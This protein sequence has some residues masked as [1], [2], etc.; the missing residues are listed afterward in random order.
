MGKTKL[1]VGVAFLA[2]AVA[3]S[4]PIASVEVANILLKDDIQDM[5][6]QFDVRT[7]YGSPKSNED[8]RQAVVRK[9][10]E[11]GIDLEDSQV[12]VERSGAGR[13][14][15]LYIAADYTESFT[16]MGVDFDLHFTP[17]SEGSFSF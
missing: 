5:A 3:A 1:I 11:H 12:T 17:S 16:F 4:Y 15:G 8:Y 14:S 13:R 6:S 2:G 10:S 9:A 7:G